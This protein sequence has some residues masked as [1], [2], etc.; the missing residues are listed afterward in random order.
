LG[1]TFSPPEFVGCGKDDHC[2]WELYSYLFKI[3]NQV[4]SLRLFLIVEIPKHS[5]IYIYIYDKPISVL[6]ASSHVHVF[7]LPTQKFWRGLYSA[8]SL[9]CV[10][11][12]W[13]LTS[14]GLR[15]EDGVFH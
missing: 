13:Y 10:R 15:L 3:P 5:Y 12:D 2:V 6:V 7:T 9:H 4:I 1:L 14:C 11:S 8:G